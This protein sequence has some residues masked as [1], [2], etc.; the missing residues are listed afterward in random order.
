MRTTVT[1]DDELYR[2]ALEIADPS[3][4]KADLFREAIKTFVRVRAAKRLAALG[5]AMPEIAEVA[6]RRPEPA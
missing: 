4:D 3:M 1:I 5:A 6:R 2:Q